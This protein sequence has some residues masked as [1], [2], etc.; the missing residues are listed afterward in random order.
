[1]FQSRTTA[2]PGRTFG[3]LYHRFAKGNTLAQG[4]LE[5]GARTV[6]L[7]A[8]S[9]PVLVVTGATDAIAPLA[10]VRPVVGLLTGAGQVRLEVVPGGHLGLLTGRTARETTWEA[11]DEWVGEWSAGVVAAP[12]KKAPATRTA[13]KKAPARKTAAK[14]APA[15]KSPAKKTAAK[16]TAATEPGSPGTIGSNPSRRYGS[17]GSRALG[18]R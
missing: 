10:A 17:S 4:H 13:A 16:K 6:D 15:K 1:V 5:L 7:A 3:Q 12:A 14:K 2:Y 18:P 8:V 11:L 9:V